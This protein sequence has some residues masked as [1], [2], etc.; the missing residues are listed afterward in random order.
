MDSIG[1]EKFAFEFHLKAVCVRAAFPTT[2]I[3]VSFQNKV[4]QRLLKELN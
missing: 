1:E 3:K 4:G 2:R